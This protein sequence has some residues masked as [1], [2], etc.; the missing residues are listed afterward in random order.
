MR[1]RKKGAVEYVLSLFLITMVVLLL[2]FNMKSRYIAI[3]KNNVEDGI[4][5]SLLASAIID[6]D[7]YG[8]TKNV[9]ISDYDNCYSLFMES[10]KGNLKLDS[11]MN[12]RDK[13]LITSKVNIDK[14][15]IYNVVDNKV[16]KIS[17]TGN[18]F[19]GQ[20]LY[21]GDVGDVVTENNIR[22]D[23]TTI[24][25]KISF[26]I[27]GYDGIGVETSKEE[28]VDITKN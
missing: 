5:A 1:V 8:T 7:E 27:S 18:G 9:V 11:N 14:F 24:Y 22:I 15:S 28:C 6:T 25:A 12:P 2:M 10:L 26:R 17:K 21:V 20:P 23:T 3:T 13:T 19:F 16:Y 4:V